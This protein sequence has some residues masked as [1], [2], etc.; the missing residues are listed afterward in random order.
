MADQ[1]L[2]VMATVLYW[3]REKHFRH[4][5]NAGNESL[6]RY[7]NDPVLKLFVAVG[8]LMEGRTTDAMRELDGLS[9]KQDVNLAAT[10]AL[11]F[12]HKQAR[13][14]DREAVQQLTTKLKAERRQ[15]NERGFYYAGLFLLN[16]DEHERAAEYIDRAVKLNPK[17]KDIL[18]LKGWLELQ[19]GR[20][21]NVNNVLK[22]FDEALSLDGPKCLDAMFGRAKCLQRDRKS[23]V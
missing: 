2:T 23:V 12:G 15:G 7:T 11:I 6:R 3:Y 20:E 9:A 5:I 18:A 13:A 8:T 14:V 17:S 10:I 22:Y 21:N 1:D 16:Q 4:M 19:S